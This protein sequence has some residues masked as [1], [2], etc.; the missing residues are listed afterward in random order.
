MR[1]TLSDYLE[2]RNMTVATVSGTQDMTSLLSAERFS[3]IILD[4][5]LGQ[6]DGLD[7]LRE[8]RA[9]TTM[10]IIL[11]TGDHNDVVDRVVGLEL[12]ADDSI[13]KPF[14]MRELFARV[15]AVLRRAEAPAEDALEPARAKAQP[16]LCFGKWTLDKRLRQLTDTEVGPVT[17]TKG[18]YVLLLAFLD[19]PRRPLSREHLLQATRLHEDV[20]DRSVDV[21][22]LRLRRKLDTDPG[23]PSV[24][25]TERGVG[26]VFTLPVE[27]F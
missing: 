1:R 8:L 21:Q 17:L 22:I 20:F 11:L 13:T 27:D 25:R 6:E 5:H 4:R 10:P 23:K 19:A 15:R 18:E 9:C 7:L 2:Q 26:Y 24:I 12:G 14:A 3:M 16:R